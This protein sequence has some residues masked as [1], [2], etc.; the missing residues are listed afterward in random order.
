V[1]AHDANE[2]ERGDAVDEL[3]GMVAIVT[4]ASAG[5][6]RATAQAPA[7]AAELRDRGGSALFAATDVADDGGFVA[8]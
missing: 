7:A 8:R 4:G 6:G 1:H 2:H 5:I 3:T